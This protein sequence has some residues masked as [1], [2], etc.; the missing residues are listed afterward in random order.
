VLE[1]GYI[2]GIRHKM[3]VWLVHMSKQC[4]ISLHVQRS[5]RARKPKGPGI[6][7]IV[8]CAGGIYIRYAIYDL[9]FP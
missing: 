5:L 4:Y 6:D 2:I 9:K 7:K 3:W 8:I 1:G